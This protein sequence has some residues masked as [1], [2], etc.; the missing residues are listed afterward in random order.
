MPST[1]DPKVFVH[2]FSEVA[3]TSTPA[4]RCRR[5]VAA[6]V[7]LG[8]LV[9]CSSSGDRGPPVG[10]VWTPSA[11]K[12][13]AEDRGGGF[14][15]VH[16]A[17]VD[18]CTYGRT[19]TLAVADRT[20]AWHVCVPT[21]TDPAYKATDGARVLTTTELATVIQA[22]DQVTVSNE[23]RCGADKG[24]VLLTITDATGDHPYLDDFYACEKK[25]TYVTNIDL[26]LQSVVPLAK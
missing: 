17:G 13:V 4:P 23:T 10:V 18:E 20:L 12:L 2:G 25:G 11:T 24:T 3:M 22:V 19:Y 6:A 14:A 16:D 26:V 15:S 21:A 7:L 1:V 5:G 8:A 9:G